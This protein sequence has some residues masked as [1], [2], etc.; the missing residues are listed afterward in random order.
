MF[1]RF[2]DMLIKISTDKTSQEQYR[3]LKRNII[4]IMMV[5][6]MVPLS[7]VVLINH[8]QLKEYLKEEIKTPLYLLLNKTKNAFEL[9]LD[10]RLSTVRFIS[11]AYTYEELNDERNIKKVLNYLKKEFNGFVDIGLINSEGVLVNYA[12]PY[13]LLG[14]N[15]FQQISFQE[16]L[17]KGKYISNVF[18]G[19]RKIPHI[20]ISV[21]HLSEEGDVWILRATVDTNSFD[22]LIKKMEINPQSDAFLLNSEGILQT[23][24][25]YYGNILEKWP[26]EIPLRNFDSC[27]MD[28][29]DH[30]GREIILCSTGFSVANYFLVMIKPPSVVLQSWQT[31]EGNMLIAFGGSI[32]FIILIVFNLS[33]IIVK[34]IELA[35][36]R[37][38]DAFTKLQHSQK[39]SSIG[40]LA[41][42]V[43]HEINNPL[44]IIN[45]KAGLM[46]DL[47]EFTEKFEN[48][49][50]FREL[51]TA[52]ISSVSRC[53]AITHR[54]LGF[55]KRIDIQIKPL[56]INLIVTNVV[57]FIE[58]EALYKNIDIRLMLSDDLNV[59][60]SDRGQ[61]Q[62]I[63]LN[64]L[65]NAVAA[66]EDHGIITISTLNIDSGGIEISV[67]DNG[68]G[69]SDD[70]MKKIYDP[71]FTTKN[72]MGTGLGLSITY[73]IVKKLSGNI[74]VESTKES[75]TTFTVHLPK[76]V[77]FDEENEDEENKDTPD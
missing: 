17:I 71:F 36:K 69:I 47:I 5:I 13:S 23:K 40:R 32:F 35:D 50:R 75:G 26:L 70:I 61:I 45:E 55:A 51:T 54:L 43:A 73:G 64:L 2:F 3:N 42:G 12:G 6:T 68:V 25:K 57:G 53:K 4:I 66:C 74:H 46:N 60:V 67:N 62:Q 77:I 9:F 18:L 16:T 76:S 59:I 41:A 34:R 24:S 52:I 29:Y 27:L 22:N 39:L 21:Q 7:I 49:T 72:E 10:G 38:E 11:T 37:R 15:Y 14:K 48:Q 19:H 58:K 30:K 44:A 8:F 28:K 63:I 56:H 31:L 65:T 1:N 33:G 20:V